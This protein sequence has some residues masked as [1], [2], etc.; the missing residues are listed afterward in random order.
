MVG[1]QQQATARLQSQ[2]AE[3]R[4]IR[5]EVQP[6]PRNAQLRSLA[7]GRQMVDFPSRQWQDLTLLTHLLSVA[8]QVFPSVCILELVSGNS[9][10]FL[11]YGFISHLIRHL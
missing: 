9:S 1:E 2:V 7:R 8:L 3:G 5:P 4:A 10:R 6:R 11:K